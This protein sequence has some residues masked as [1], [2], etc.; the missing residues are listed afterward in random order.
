MVAILFARVQFVHGHSFIELN[1]NRT[2]KTAFVY[3]VFH[4]LTPNRIHFIYHLFHNK[5]DDWCIF[6]NVTFIQLSNSSH[7]IICVD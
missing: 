5:F 3:S 7:K 6:N 1:Y 2:L 4:L